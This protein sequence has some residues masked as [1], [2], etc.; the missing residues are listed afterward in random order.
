MAAPSS[1]GD[2][3]F[4]SFAMASRFFP[5]YNIDQPVGPGKPNRPD[6]VRLVQ[7]LFI[8]VSRFDANDWF[9]ELPPGARSLATTGLFDDTL[10]QWIEVFQRW[11]AGNSGKRK[12][13]TDGIVDPMPGPSSI[14][15]SPTFASGRLSTLG[16]LC[17]RLWRFNRDAYLR[18]GDAYRIPWIPRGWDT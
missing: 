11:A 3:L 6:D 12:F 15:V 17:N 18:I 5:L 9:K 16:F 8:E 14:A 13:K 10:K 1:G 2:Q 4:G 7:A